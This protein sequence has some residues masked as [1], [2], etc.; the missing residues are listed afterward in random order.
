MQYC[1]RFSAERTD[2]RRSQIQVPDQSH[3]RGGGRQVEPADHSRHDVRQQA[4]LSRVVAVG[5]GHFLQY[6]RRSAADAAR[7]GDHHQGRRPDASAEVGLQPD[8]A[9]HRAAAG[10]GADGGLGTRI[11]AGERG[12]RHPGAT[13]GGGRPEDVARVHGGTARAAPGCAPAPP[14]DIGHVTTARRL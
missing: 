13:A 9:G 1:K 10:A 7:A 2:E 8:R 4:A 3:A 12:T 11:P 5:G 14:R 6:P